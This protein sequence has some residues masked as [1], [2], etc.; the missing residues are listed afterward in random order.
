MVLPI[1]VTISTIG[2]TDLGS[3]LGA[4]ARKYCVDIV[5]A[6]KLILSRS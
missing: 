5:M 1:E 2:G 4:M 6:K 3:R